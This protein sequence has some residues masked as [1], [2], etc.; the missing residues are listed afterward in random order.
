[1]QNNIE[2]KFYLFRK[3]IHA[4]NTCNSPMKNLHDTFGMEQWHKEDFYC[5]SSI[6]YHLTHKTHTNT[7]MKCFL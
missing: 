1:M 4:A 5:K 7:N 2:S 6:I 3:V